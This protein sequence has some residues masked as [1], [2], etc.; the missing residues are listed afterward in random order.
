MRKFDIDNEYLILIDL[1]FSVTEIH[2]HISTVAKGKHQVS[3][4]IASYSV[5]T[6]SECFK[7]CLGNIWCESI[8]I[9]TTAGSPSGKRIC[10]SIDKKAAKT[11]AEDTGW[12]F[13]SLDWIVGF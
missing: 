2:A 8:N 10:Q 4:I 5:R 13:Y 1:H 9:A 3:G 7:I 12:S 6:L 11:I